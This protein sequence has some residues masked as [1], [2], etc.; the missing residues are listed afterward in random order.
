MSTYECNICHKR[1]GKQSAIKCH[2]CSA[3]QHI[4]CAKLTK[5]ASSCPNF[6]ETY[7]CIVCIN[8]IIPFQQVS[9]VEFNELFQCHFN[10]GVCKQIT[11]TLNKEI[12]LDEIIK[13]DCKYRSV[14]WY[15]NC[16]AL[17]KKPNNISLLHFNVRSIIKNKHLIEELLSEINYCPH[18]LAISET[19][20]NDDK[21]KYALI[22]NYNSVFSNS[23]SNAGGVAFYVLNNLSFNRRH[24]LE[25]KSFDS[26]NLFI[27]IS[28]S[29]S[30]IIVLGLIYRHPNNNFAEFQDQFLKTINKLRQDKQEFIISGDFNIDLLKH[31]TNS[32]INDYINAVHSEGCNNIINKPTRITESSATLID[33]IYT[34]ITDKITNRGI[35]TFDISDHLPTFCLTDLKTTKKQEKKLIRDMKNFDKTNFLEDVKTLVQSNNDFL[36]T[37]EEYNPEEIFN[38]FLNSFSELVNQH[39]PL[40]LQTKR[41]A[42]INT[43]PWL[44]NGLLKSIQTKNAM[45]KKCYKKNDPLLI[46]NYKKFSNKLTTIKRIAKQNYYATMIKLNKKN[47]SKHWQ[48]INQILQRNNKQ[49]QSINK[50]VTENN[51]T[52]TDCKDICDELNNYFTNIG[53]N[54]ASKLTTNDFDNSPSN[55][56]TSL[57]NSFFCEP[58]SELETFQEIM[59]LNEKK[60]AGFENIPI[61]YLK[62]SAEYV[63][64]LLSNLFN[65]CILEGIF[66][67][68]LKIAKITPL[69][70]GGCTNKATNY[71]PIS[72]LSPFSKIF[73]KLIYRRLIKYFE[74]YNIIT[75]FQFGFRAKHS[76]NHVIYDVINNLQTYRDN[77]QFACLILLDLSKAFDTVNHGILLNKLQKYGIRGK[78]L[79]LIESYLTNRQ[80]V[81]YIPNTFSKSQKVLCGV[82]QGSVLGPLLFS[83]Y[84][85]DLPN[86]SEFETR[87]F[88]DDTALFL[89]DKDLKSLNKKVNT[90]LIK[91]EQ[92]LNSNKLSLNYSKTNYLLI[93][94][95]SRNPN[96]NFTINIKGIEIKQSHSAKYLGIIIDENLDWKPHI[97]YLHKKLSHTVGIIAKMR[98][99]LNNQNLIGLYYAF[100][101]SHALYGILGWGS[102]AKT[103]LKPLQILQNKVLRIINN[104]SWKDYVKNNVLYKKYK[105]LKFDDIYKFELG[106]FMYLYHIKDLPE[107]FESY[108]LPLDQTHNHNTRNKSNNNY[109]LKSIRTNAGKNA[110]KYCG[111]QLWLN[112]PALL[113]SYS[114][115]RFKKEYTKLL[116]DQYL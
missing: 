53:P 27:E 72:I 62:I 73:E 107:I 65:K 108:F 24:D 113:K 84:I 7:Y 48:L 32:K 58:C 43:K 54:M 106:K 22:Q 105:V 50:L 23:S 103:T 42:Q 70:K 14:E 29:P 116:L 61:K 30:K 74:T 92:W 90:E 89:S 35:L 28:L 77:K 1:C 12:N 19:K 86:S 115:Y 101:Y 75:K 82:P 66:P 78:S 17:S 47:M 110:I 91:I 93:R 10:Q 40:R 68:M 37:I 109:F 46:E 20:L 95:K 39:A 56:L 88:A 49:K 85:N 59:L 44:S 83:V 25:F 81:V 67:S 52:L 99:Y 6:I 60:A 45:F 38:A 18:I 34:N 51:V 13:T 80:Q 102:A 79:K 69:Y 100:F 111:V 112:I 96:Y 97:Q 64:F 87:L 41:E 36:S 76:T 94:P 15:K 55:S 8:S 71:R 98:Y 11:G 31:E 114:Y 16:V 4:R 5:Q 2:N 21:I 63:S 26:E 57:P 33:H 104:T 3:L 9:N